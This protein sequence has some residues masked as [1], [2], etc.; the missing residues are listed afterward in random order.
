MDGHSKLCCKI[1][2]KMTSIVRKMIHDPC[3]FYN[4]MQKFKCSAFVIFKLIVFVDTNRISIIILLV[5]PY[6][7]CNNVLY[8]LYTL[9]VC[10]FVGK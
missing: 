9:H 6:I 2:V 10:K 3:C 5:V 7:H 4:N 8:K 1:E